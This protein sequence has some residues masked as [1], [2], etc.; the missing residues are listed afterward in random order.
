MREIRQKLAPEKLESRHSLKSYSSQ[1][2][3]NN[4]KELSGSSFFDIHITEK[5]NMGLK[6]ETPNYL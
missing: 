6:H 5:S 3:Q 1:M 4:Y 2:K